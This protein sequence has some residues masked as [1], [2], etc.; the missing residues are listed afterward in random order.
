MACIVCRG[1]TARTSALRR[2]LVECVTCGLV[3]APEATED[4]AEFDSHYYVE[5]AYADYVQDRDA[6]HRSAVTRLQALERAV[7]GRRLLDVGCAAGYFLEAARTRGWSVAGLE[8][9]AYAVQ[10]ARR[11]AL[12]IFEASILAPPSLP[13]FDAITMWDTIEH[14]PRPDI[15]VENARRLLRP[16]GVLAISTGDRR[17][18]VARALGRRWRLMND[19]THKFFFD[20]PTLSSLL[21]AAGFTVV[22]VSRPG[23]WVSAAMILHQLPSGPTTFARRALSARGWNPAL[24]VNLWDV[25]TMIARPTGAEIAPEIAPVVASPLSGVID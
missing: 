17:S 3:Y 4:R 9:S 20:A 21:A 2:D 19:P 1:A 23:K 16:G 8:L 22:S 12:D 7:R 24:Y 14:I 10:L 11:L 5:G 25:M 18:L 13:G 6:I 15:A